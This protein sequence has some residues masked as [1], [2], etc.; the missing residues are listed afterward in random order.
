[1]ESY[2]RSYFEVE[3]IAFKWSS[4]YYESTDGLPFIGH[5]PG[6]PSNIFV[7]TGFGGN[8]MIYGTIA[9]SVLTDLINSE[10][11]DLKDLFNPARLKP[12]AGFHNFVKE[13][14]DV[15]KEFVSGKFAAD[16]IELLADM[17]T[18]EGRVV[19]YENSKVA[20]YK[21]ELHKIHAVNPTCTHIKCTVAWNET[22]KSWDCPCHGARF[23]IDGTVLNGP[24][25]K[26]LPQIHL[27]AS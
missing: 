1:M 13:A 26:D 6:K 4:Q 17:A 15:V 19:E 21:D 7:A 25:S 3:D 5:L 24:A 2:V 20:L 9:A 10:S 14:A 27:N 12:I 16:K 11:S 22:E 23:S 18:G 8:G